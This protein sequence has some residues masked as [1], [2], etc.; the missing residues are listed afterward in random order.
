M[1]NVTPSFFLVTLYL[2][3]PSCLFSLFSPLPPFHPI[4]ERGL[5]KKSGG[6]LQLPEN[7]FLR[8]NASCAKKNSHAHFSVGKNSQMFLVVTA[9]PPGADPD[10]PPPVHPAA[11]GSAAATAAA[12]AASRRDVSARRVGGRSLQAGL[13]RERQTYFYLR[14]FIK[15]NEFE[16][17]RFEYF[18]LH[19]PRLSHCCLSL[20]TL[21]AWRGG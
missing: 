20:L 18:L 17:K 11:A 13:W 6:T 8:K 12:A 14:F 21:P 5:C 16:Y 2:V 1:A 7:K 19:I 3:P 15:K 4:T 10:S 9:A